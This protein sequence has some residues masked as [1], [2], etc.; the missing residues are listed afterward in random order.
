LHHQLTTTTVSAVIDVVDSNEVGKWGIKLESGVVIW[1]HD[2]S[3]PKPLSNIV[4][5]VLPR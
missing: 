2:V 5:L 4:G 1:N 3:M